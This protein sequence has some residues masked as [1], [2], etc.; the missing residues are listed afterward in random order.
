MAAAT[1]ATIAAPAAIHSH[2][3]ISLCGNSIPPYDNRAL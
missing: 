2:G 1:A 3:A